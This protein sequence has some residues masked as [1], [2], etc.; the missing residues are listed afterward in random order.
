MKQLLSTAVLLIAVAAS[1]AW[2]QDEDAP[3]LME[4]GA[5][6]F[7]EGVL[8]E[9]EP[10]L[11]GM[12]ELADDV[13]PALRDFV[14]HMGPALNDLLETVEDWSV[15]E[16]PEILPNGD[17]ILRRKPPEKDVPQPDTPEIEL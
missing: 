2:A 5:R 16:P 1:P 6:L 17:I 10:A 13:R 14:L 8:Q 12:K 15:Y 7:M 11:D 3:S 4:R 9:M